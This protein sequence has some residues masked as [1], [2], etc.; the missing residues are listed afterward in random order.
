MDANLFFEF[1]RI[2]E[3]VIVDCIFQIF[4][5]QDF[6]GVNVRVLKKRRHARHEVETGLFFS[7]KRDE[8]FVS[9]VDNP[10]LLPKA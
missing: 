10:G 7:N 6:L 4:E 8:S 2:L 9:E 5:V 3:S 1:R